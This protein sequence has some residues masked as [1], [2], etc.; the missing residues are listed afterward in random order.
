[1][2]ALQKHH[3]PLKKETWEQS[4][5]ASPLKVS[6]DTQMAWSSFHSG[7]INKHKKLKQ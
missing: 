3:K 1:M 6:F 4:R 7:M 5:I 2:S